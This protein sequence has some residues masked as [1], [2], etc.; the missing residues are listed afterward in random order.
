MALPCKDILDGFVPVVVLETTVLA[1]LLA[2][3]L[4]A[5]PVA[6]PRDTTAREVTPREEVLLAAAG[7]A[8]DV[9]EVVLATLL[10]PDVAVVPRDTTARDVTLREGLEAVVVAVVVLEIVLPEPRDVA[11]EFLAEPV[12]ARCACVVSNSGAIGSAK[13][14]LIDKNVEQTKNAPASK[15]TV[16]IAFLHV[17]ANLWFFINTLLCSR[18]ARKS[19]ILYHA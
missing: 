4:D 11:P 19:G 5:L 15:K 6:V 9:E 14:A 8:V 13:T 17:S 1:V 16:P 12:V 18:N 2:V 7:L 3:V 10:A